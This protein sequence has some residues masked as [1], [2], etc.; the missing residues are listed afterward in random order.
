MRRV[1]ASD[2][3][4]IRDNYPRAG[5]AA[6]RHLGLTRGQVHGVV[7][8]EGIKL[9]RAARGRAISQSVWGAQQRPVDGAGAWK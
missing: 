2:I 6:V 8:A 4:A 3:D 5:F 1:T 9:T 7:R